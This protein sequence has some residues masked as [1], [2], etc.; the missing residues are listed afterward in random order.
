MTGEVLAKLV[1]AENDDWVSMGFCTHAEAA[2]TLAKRND[3]SGRVQT[4]NEG[5]SRIF[6]AYV[7]VE[8]R[9]RVD[10]ERGDDD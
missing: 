1:N 10:F 4:K 2:L 7:E 3:Y 6:N 8:I 9:Y 5:G